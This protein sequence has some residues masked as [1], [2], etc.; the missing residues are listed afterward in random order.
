MENNWWFKKSAKMLSV[1]LSKWLYNGWRMLFPDY[2][3][4]LVSFSGQVVQWINGLEHLDT[5]VT[6]YIAFIFRTYAIFKMAS[7]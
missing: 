1:L 4:Y 3:K 6:S 2:T 5:G 7:K